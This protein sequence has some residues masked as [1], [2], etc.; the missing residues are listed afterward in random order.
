MAAPQTDCGSQE[1]MQASVPSCRVRL[2]HDSDLSFWPDRLHG[3]LQRRQQGRQK[4]TAHGY[5]GRGGQ[6]VQVLQ[7]KGAC[8]CFCAAKICGKGIAM[9]KK[10]GK[11]TCFEWYEFAV[12]VS[13]E[14]FCNAT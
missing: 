9:R 11:R 6:I 5:L 12:D 13:H 7:L 2:D 4:A 14:R 1:I 10:S 8:G 3:V